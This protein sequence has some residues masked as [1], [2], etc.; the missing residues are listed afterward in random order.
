MGNVG[1]L[2]VMTSLEALPWSFI[3]VM[4]GSDGVDGHSLI[5]E[6]IFSSHC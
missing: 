4:F 5:F 6:I 2:H 1:I 3:Y